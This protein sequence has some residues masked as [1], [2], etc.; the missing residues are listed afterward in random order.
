MTIEQDLIEL[1]ELETG[2]DPEDRCKYTRSSLRSLAKR[3]GRGS[4]TSIGRLLK[5]LGYSLKTNV[6]RLIGK[7]HPQRDWQYRFIQ[8]TKALFVRA[9]QPVISI[10]AKKSELIGNF[11]N[12]GRRYCRKADTVNAY[13]FPSEAECKAT[14]YGIYDSQAEQALVM[15]GQSAVTSEFAVSSIR[16]WWKQFGV[17]RYSQAKHLLIEADAGGCNG[18]R[19]RLW[20]L[21]LQRLVD[22]IGFPITVCHYPSGAS[23]W[24]PIEHRLF[25]QISRNWAGHPLRTLT[26]MLNFLRG[27]TTTKG[28]KV[29]AGLDTAT[30]EKGIKVSDKE[31]KSLNLHRRRICPDL[32]YTI[33]PRKSGSNF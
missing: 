26:I 15:V 4:A 27:T 19:G 22:E 12:S 5:P 13:D 28:L 18:Y 8:R 33:K 6:K 2:G 11:K 25:S 9:G 29:D 32:S 21:E 16:H 14:P 20:K 3:L 24:T 1:V 10:D 23:K 30:Y 31:M 7:I 17:A